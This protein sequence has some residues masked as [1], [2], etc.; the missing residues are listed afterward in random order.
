ML[1]AQD[2]VQRLNDQLKSS[3]TSTPTSNQPIDPTASKDQN[4]SSEDQDTKQ[5][6]LDQKQTSQ[7]SIDSDESNHHT[8]SSDLKGLPQ[9]FGQD[10]DAKGT[11]FYQ[12]SVSLSIVLYFTPLKTYSSYLTSLRLP[13]VYE[14]T[15][16]SCRSMWECE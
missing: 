2:K 16:R 6:D 7:H 13:S 8:P 11:Y 4:S 1:V 9:V 14:Y 15:G 3:T 12:V 10:G 5:L